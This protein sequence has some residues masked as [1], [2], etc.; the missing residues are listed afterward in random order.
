[1]AATSDQNDPYAAFNFELRINGVTVAALSEGNGLIMENDV[2]DYRNVGENTTIRNLPGLRKSANISFKRGYTK[3]KELWSWYKSVI[4]GKT[5]R[6]S[7]S[8]VLK[9][10]AGQ[11]A[12]RWTFSQGWPVKLE[13][14]SLNSTGNETAIETLEIA[15]E[16]LRAV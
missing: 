8:I 13:S 7:G 5:E 9:D 10:E 2:A 11:H 14:S 6:R 1:M 3:D 4:D 15:V 16:D 12:L